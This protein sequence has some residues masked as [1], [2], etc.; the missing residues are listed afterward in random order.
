YCDFCQCTFPDN[1]K[2]RKNH[3]EGI[4][5]VNNRKLHYDWY[6]V[7][8]PSIFLQEQIAKPPCRHYQQYGYC[9]FGILCK[10]SHITYDPNTG[11]YIYPPELIQWFQLQQEEALSSTVNL[12]VTEKTKKKRTRYKLPSGWKVKDLPPSLKP[13]PP[14]HGY[15]WNQVGSWS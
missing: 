6:K 13:P 8:D 12:E 14:K 1:V 11:Q 5:H 7:I 3:N 4:A 10:Y 9:E 2:N 15:D